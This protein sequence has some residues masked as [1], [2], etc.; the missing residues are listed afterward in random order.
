VSE[1][2]ELDSTRDARKEYEEQVTEQRLYL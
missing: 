2:S 1:V